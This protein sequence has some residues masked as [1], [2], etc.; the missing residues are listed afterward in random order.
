[1]R[2]SKDRQKFKKNNP[3]K[4]GLSTNLNYYKKLSVILYV[5]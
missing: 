4:W 2:N 1:M 3:Q 5:V